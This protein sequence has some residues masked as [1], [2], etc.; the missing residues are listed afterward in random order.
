MSKN[1]CKVEN[2]WCKFCKKNCGCKF[3]NTPGVWTPLSTIHKCPVREKNETISFR[4]LLLSVSFFDMM[5]AMKKYWPDEERNI[6][7]Y[8]SVYIKL[9]GVHGTRSNMFISGKYLYFDEYDDNGNKLDKQSCCPGLSVVHK[10]RPHFRY[11]V[12]GFPWA[13]IVS[14]NITQDTL[15][16]MTPE[17][18]VAGVLFELTFNGFTE[19]KVNEF[20]KDLEAR[21]NKMRNK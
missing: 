7:G 20:F 10:N 14:M 8:R 1:F 12:D 2:K 17:D 6:R 15:N 11:S 19:E 4:N 3:N 21:L 13:E 16:N 9:L 18:I 5:N